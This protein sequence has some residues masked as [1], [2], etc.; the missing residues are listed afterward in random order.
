MGVGAGRQVE[1]EPLLAVRPGTADFRHE[2][3]EMRGLDHP[4]FSR[5]NAKSLIL[6]AAISEI[7]TT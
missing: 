6:F 5:K 1:T 4:K 2:A 3:A 7:A